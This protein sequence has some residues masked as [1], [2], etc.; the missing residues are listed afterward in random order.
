MTMRRTGK[1]GMGGGGGDKF[2]L[3]H[4]RY[5]FIL[6]FFF[7]NEQFKRTIVSYCRAKWKQADLSPLSRATA[8]AC[9]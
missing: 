8:F 7:A 6:I 4:V 5:V 3:S 2:K 9:N 1:E